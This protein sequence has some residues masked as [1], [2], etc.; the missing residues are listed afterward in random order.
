[1]LQRRHLTI[2]AIGMLAGLA[3]AGVGFTGITAHAQSTSTTKTVPATPAPAAATPAPATTAA[4]A[5]LVN[6][7]TATAQELDA[8]PQIGEKRAA[9]IIKKRPYASADE[10]VSKKVLSQG[11]FD[12]IK[13][14][15]TV[16]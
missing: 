14:K 3:L 11:V 15:I 9:A 4:P 13:D 10:L 8:L 16:R 1:M 12:K 7:N 2:A 6:I 5:T